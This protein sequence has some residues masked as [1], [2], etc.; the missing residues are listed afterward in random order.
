[1]QMK[2]FTIIEL[3]LV[4]AIVVAIVGILA[5]IAAPAFMKKD[6]TSMNDPNIQCIGGYLHNA[7]TGQQIFNSNGVGIPCR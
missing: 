6:V 1:M 4:V 2:G 5:I 7:H 3:L